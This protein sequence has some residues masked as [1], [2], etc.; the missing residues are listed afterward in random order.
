[1]Q[2]SHDGFCSHILD[3]RMSPADFFWVIEVRPR[4]SC[5][6][7][8]YKTKQQLYHTRSNSNLW[9]WVWWLFMATYE[10]RHWEQNRSMLPVKE[11]TNHH[12]HKH[13][14]LY[15]HHNLVIW[16]I[17]HIVPTC[18]MV[19]GF[20]PLSKDNRINITMEWVAEVLSLVFIGLLVL[21]V[22]CKKTL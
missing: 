7:L 17:A 12:V 1:M 20:S 15:C 11:Q 2:S 16:G 3:K 9:K 6:H 10:H 13:F 8:K 19:A 14:A 5:S 4:T 21:L 22:V 18:N